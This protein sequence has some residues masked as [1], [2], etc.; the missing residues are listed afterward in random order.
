MKEDNVEVKMTDDLKADWLPIESVWA[1]KDKYT[2]LLWIAWIIEVWD[3]YFLKNWQD[4]LI[5]QLINFPDVEHDDEMDAF[6]YAM[7]EAQK[8]LE[9]WWETWWVEIL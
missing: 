6:V 7:I 3:V 8:W 2:R 4:T 1:H 5:E 9:W